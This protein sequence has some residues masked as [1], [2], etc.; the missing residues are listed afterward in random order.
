MPSIQYSATRGRS[1]ASELVKN[2]EVEAV[3][4]SSWRALRARDF[5]RAACTVSQG[6][7]VRVDSEVHNCRQSFAASSAEEI[8]EME[9]DLLI[10]I[11]T[12]L[13][14]P[15]EL[16]TSGRNRNFLACESF[17]RMSN[18]LSD[19]NLQCMRRECENMHAHAFYLACV[20]T[21][22]HGP[23]VPRALHAYV[24]RA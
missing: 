10:A 23:C 8:E 21:H 14:S 6:R 1:V 3:L 11:V 7:L 20:R 13:S 16:C 22:A 19:Q 5:I 9:M 15:I 2:L 12:G 17:S 4:S 18:C 24:A